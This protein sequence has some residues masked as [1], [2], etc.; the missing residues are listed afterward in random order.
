VIEVGTRDVADV[1]IVLTPGL[2]VSGHVVVDGVRGP[3]GGG[4]LAVQL[5]ARVNGQSAKPVAVDGSF[6]FDNVAPQD[7]WLRI[8]S[9]GRTISPSSIRFGPDAP[10]DG[11]VRVTPERQADELVIAVTLRT[12]GV[13]VAVIDRNQR[14]MS[15]VT[16]AL[17][18]DSARRRYSG[19]F[20]TAS[21]DVDGRVQFNDIEPGRYTLLSG[22]VAPADWQ[23]PEVIQRFERTAIAVQVEPAARQRVSLVAP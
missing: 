15:G 1:N 17:I 5:V 6:T 10:T 22:D 14:P 8:L 2:R 7:Y 23:N 21:S 13:D 18:P 3:T 20:R 4:L 16:V 19:L 9:G 12:G 11:V